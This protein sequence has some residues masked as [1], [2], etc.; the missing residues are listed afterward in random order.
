MSNKIITVEPFKSKYKKWKHKLFECP[1]FWKSMW[2]TITKSKPF[3]RCPQCN[4]ALHCYW[5]GNDTKKGI[6]FCDKCASKH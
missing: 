5:D 2:N 3:Y 6:D 4:K 1:S